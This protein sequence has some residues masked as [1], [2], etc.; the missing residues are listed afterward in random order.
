MQRNNMKNSQ[1]NQ[2]FSLIEAA[3]D[4]GKYAFGP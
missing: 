4:R 2:I 1:Q 3:V